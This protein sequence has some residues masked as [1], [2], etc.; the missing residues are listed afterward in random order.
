MYIPTLISFICSLDDHANDDHRA[1]LMGK[2][3][4]SRKLNMVLITVSSIG[5]IVFFL[6]IQRQV[7]VSDRQFFKRDAPLIT[8]QLS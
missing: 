1:G 3:Y 2:M 7:A 8:E 4:P 5:L 6:L